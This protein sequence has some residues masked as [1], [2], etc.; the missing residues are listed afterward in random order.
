MKPVRIVPMGCD[1]IEAVRDFLEGLEVPLNRT[2][3]IFPGKRPGLYLKEALAATINRV[4]GGPRVVRVLF[5][6]FVII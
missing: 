5:L 6:Q 2:A 1:F 3:I 4:I